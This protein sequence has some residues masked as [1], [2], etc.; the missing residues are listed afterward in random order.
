MLNEEGIAQETQRPGSDRYWRGSGQGR[1]TSLL[2][3]QPEE[4]LY[5]LLASFQRKEFLYEQPA[6]PEPDYIFKQP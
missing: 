6:F 2:F 4:A 1:A 3:A 5:H